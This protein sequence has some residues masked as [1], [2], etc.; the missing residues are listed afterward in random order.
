MKRLLNNGIEAGRSLLKEERAVLEKI[1]GSEVIIRDV[2]YGCQLVSQNRYSDALLSFMKAYDNLKVIVEKDDNPLLKKVFC[3]SCFNIG[4][5]YNELEQF[6]TAACYLVL[7][8]EHF[9][10]V[11]YAMEYINALVNGNNC[12]FAM[13]V[14]E[15]HLHEWSEGR[16]KN[17]PENVIFR[18]YLCRCLAYL[19]IKRGMRYKA[20]KLLEKI[21][22]TPEDREFALG[23]LEYLFSLGD[24]L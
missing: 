3:K 19:Y 24:I 5:C 6:D 7:M 14:V 18:R 9:S 22:K 8:Q 2:D 20:F 21:K 16:W 10:N 12:S 13:C 4:Y 11:Q 15:L 17:A 1:T 23:E